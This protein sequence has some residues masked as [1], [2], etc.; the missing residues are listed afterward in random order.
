MYI[1]EEVTTCM[2]CVLTDIALTTTAGL[3]NDHLGLV[4][5]TW[6]VPSV[7]TLKDGVDV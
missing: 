1:N 3:D 7:Q 4:L 6:T 5:Q 2:S